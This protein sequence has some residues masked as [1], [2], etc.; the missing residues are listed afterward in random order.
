MSDLS[1]TDPKEIPIDPSETYRALNDTV[2]RLYG[3]HRQD[4][5]I[6]LITDASAELEPWRAELAHLKACLLGSL[7]NHDEALDTLATAHAAGSWWDPRILEQDDDLTG[8]RGL[9]P[10]LR[11]VESSRVQWEQAN[12]DPDRSGDRL[13][14]PDAAPLGNS[15]TRDI[16]GIVVALHGAEEDADDALA[17]WGSATTDGFAV[18]AIRSSQR[19]S[20]HYRSWPDPKQAAAEI[21]EALRRLPEPL[22]SLPLIAAGFSAGGRVALQWA[23]SGNPRPVSGV[24]VVAPAAT[25]GTLPSRASD[26]ELVPA[27]IVV[28]ADDDLADDVVAVAEELGSGPPGHFALDVVPG[29]GHGFPE[30]FAARLGA[31]LDPVQESSAVKPTDAGG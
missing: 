26:D 28:G 1:G 27:L 25:A 18:L 11:L 30:D 19:T 12:A 2:F 31:A 21:A 15:R 20:P 23:L 3:E 9:D 4:E 13:A 29:L 16:R 17:A 8:L 14:L 6:D 10:F 24:I 5:A 7:G 22:R